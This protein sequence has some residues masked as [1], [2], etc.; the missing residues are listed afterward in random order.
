MEIARTRSEKCL[1]LSIGNKVINLKFEIMTKGFKELLALAIAAS[2]TTFDELDRLVYQ[3][4]NEIT[5][6]DF[7]QVRQKLKIKFV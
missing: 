7:D 4:E 6:A 5:G 1:S 2:V 3:C